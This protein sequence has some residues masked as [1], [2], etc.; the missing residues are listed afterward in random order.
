[1]NEPAQRDYSSVP[2]SPTPVPFP[3]DPP[4]PLPPQSPASSPATPGYT[5]QSLT[6][7]FSL[8]KLRGLVVGVTGVVNALVDCGASTCFMSEQLVRTS[9][10]KVRTRTECRITLGNNTECSTDKEVDVV[11]TL[12]DGTVLSITCLVL[13]LSADCILGMDFLRQYNPSIDWRKQS[14]TFQ[15][16]NVAPCEN[17]R[18][19]KRKGRKAAASGLVAHLHVSSSVS[20]DAASAHVAPD[21]VPTPVSVPSPQTNDRA[22][23]SFCSSRVIPPRPVIVQRMGAVPSAP[24]VPFAHTALT[25]NLNRP[26]CES[27]RPPAQTDDCISNAPIQTDSTPLEYHELKQMLSRHG[28]K[29]VERLFLCSVSEVMNSPAAPPED[30]C[31]RH[32]RKKYPTVFSNDTPFPPTR[33]IHDHTIPLVPG[34]QPVSKAHYRL[35]TSELDELQKQISELLEKGFIRPSTSSFGAPVLFVKKHDGSL[36]MCVDY[37][38]L[39]DITVKNK[40]PLPRIDELITRLH[41]ATYFSK[42]DL[43]SGYHQLQVAEQDRHKTAFRTRYGSYEFNVMSFGLTNAPSSFMALMHDVL[44]GLVDRSVVVYLDDIIIYTRGSHA[45]HRSKVEE[46]LQRLQKHSLIVNQKKCSFFQSAVDFLGFRVSRDG[47][48]MESQ[49]VQAILNLGAPRTLKQ[50]RSFL[51][52]IGFYRDFIPNFSAVSAPL[53]ELTQKEKSWQWGEAQ[54]QSFDAMKKLLTSAPVL[55]LPD[56]RQPFVVNAD[57]SGVGAGAVLQQVDKNG[58]LRPCAYFSKK[59]LPAET[60]YSTHEQEMLAIILALKH[61]RHFLY[62][63]HFTIRTDHRSLEHFV[64]QPQLN[65][66]Q[67]RWAELLADYDFTIQYQSGDTNVVADILSR[68][69]LYDEGQRSLSH[70]ST[71]TTT[72]VSAELKEAGKVDVDYCAL[73]NG[74]KKHGD[75]FSVKNGL[76]YFHDRVV[77]PSSATSLQ[78]KLLSECHETP[79]G[80]HYGVAKT[81]EL[82]TRH[83]YWKKQHETVRCFVDSCITCSRSKASNALSAGLLQP[84]E[85]PPRRWDVITMDFIGPLPTTRAGHNAILTVVDKFSKFS[86]FIPCHMSSSAAVVASLV[87][88]NVIRHH[89]MPSTIISDRD[90]RFTAV[91]WKTVW[92]RLGTRLAM[93]TAWHPQ[94]DGQSERANRTVEQYVRS[95]INYK[96]TNWDTLL[97]TAELSYNNTVNPSTGYTPFFLQTGQHPRL[98]VSVGVES[99]CEAA[100]DMLSNLSKCLEHCADNLQEAQHKQKQY[101]DKR[102]QDV[103]YSVGDMV[104]LRANHLKHDALTGKFTSKYIGPV[105]V[106]SK[107]SDLVYKLQ[108]PLSMSRTHNTFHVSRLRRYTPSPPQFSTRVTLP[109]SEPPAELLDN[110]EEV[111]EV[112]RILKKRTRR[113]GRGSRTEYLVKWKNCAVESST[114]EPTTS[115]AQ[116]QWSIDE[117]HR[118]LSNRS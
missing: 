77:I 1:M 99:T 4:D 47:V 34:S 63:R 109:P 52:V 57:A 17:S 45:D 100:E 38:Q 75:G 102:R 62:R 15:S 58:T 41:G 82:L 54:Q 107:I 87:F 61:W 76:V 19:H 25:A 2:Y 98:P 30:S 84:I 101:A 10:L 68:N 22:S 118:S 24:P 116:C 16:E 88:D 60:R 64:Q 46:V 115:L 9:G 42:I 108:L 65:N 106:V 23:V 21:R 104:L 37:R 59:L 83:Y 73:L 67:R 48:E 72:D 27:R 11:F 91:F 94:T 85:T 117:F 12:T 39:N 66:R 26:D 6:S 43:K 32:M 49:K 36:R 44:S 114:W 69:P 33:P 29:E 5:L 14:I 111:W 79:I 53:S 31:M 8:L 56:D 35:S 55:L 13:P 81:A 110:G 50:V 3:P 51:G 95:F 90:V 93:S 86:H 71:V 78:T 70:M 28:R 112:E 80:G 103:Q 74:D 92:Q 97:T 20:M 96:Q 40:Y 105:E 113:Y 89:G 7:T 18:K